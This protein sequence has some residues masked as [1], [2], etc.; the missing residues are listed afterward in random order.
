MSYIF[1]NNGKNVVGWF[2]GV[3]IGSKNRGFKA[4]IRFWNDE[5]IFILL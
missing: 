3:D 2:I 4:I 5:E 1:H